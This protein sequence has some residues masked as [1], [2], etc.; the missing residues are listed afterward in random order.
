MWFSII[1]EFYLDGIKL[2]YSWRLYA[3][4]VMI[5]RQNWLKCALIY[6]EG[7]RVLMPQLAGFSLKNNY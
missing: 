6:V 1:K 5:Y 7:I 3:Q 2:H 4:G